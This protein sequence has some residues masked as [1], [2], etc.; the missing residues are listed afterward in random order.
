MIYEKIFTQLIF[1]FRPVEM[2]M[3]QMKNPQWKQYRL[4]NHLN[5]LFKSYY[6]KPDSKNVV[7]KLGIIHE[8]AT[9][10]FISENKDIYIYMIYLFE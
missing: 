2:P 1:F 3:H 7:I 4:I 6:D 8:N 5:L 9:Y 10:I